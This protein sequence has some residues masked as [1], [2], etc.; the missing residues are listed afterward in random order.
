MPTITYVSACFNGNIFL[1]NTQKILLICYIYFYILKRENLYK[2]ILI[3]FL[4]ILGLSN[5]K[6]VN[7]YKYV[8][9]KTF[10]LIL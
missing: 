8:C 10:H 9:L 7:H 2:H 5:A 6:Y 4:S 3:W 1:K